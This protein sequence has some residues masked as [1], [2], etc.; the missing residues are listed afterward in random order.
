[1]GTLNAV[2]KTSGS[3]REG[4][5]EIHDYNSNL[6]FSF[7]K[8]PKPARTCTFPALAY[9]HPITAKSVIGRDNPLTQA[10]QRPFAILAHFLRPFLNGGRRWAAF[11]LA[12]PCAR[13]VTPASSASIAVTSMVVDSNPC[14]GVTA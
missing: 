12:G 2:Q 4:L 14:T 10:Q 13:F 11:G 3:G 8:H 7:K 9:N 5:E 1:M 6:E